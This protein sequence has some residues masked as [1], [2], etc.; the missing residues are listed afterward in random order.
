MLARDEPGLVS[1]DVLARARQLRLDEIA[2]LLERTTWRLIDTAPRDG[3]PIL[4]WS[5]D[6]TSGFEESWVVARWQATPSQ[7][8][9]GGAWVSA[10]GLPMVLSHWM[11]LPPRPNPPED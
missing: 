5:N 2:R 4:G 6:L 8:W 7:P 11:P 9:P 10:L 3:T 1:H